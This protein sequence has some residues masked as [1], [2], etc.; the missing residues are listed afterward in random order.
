[1]LFPHRGESHYLP[2]NVSL[3]KDLRRSFVFREV[4]TAGIFV[5][6]SCIIRRTGAYVSQEGGSTR[7]CIWMCS[8]ISR[9]SQ[10]STLDGLQW[11]EFGRRAWRGWWGSR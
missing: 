9:L 11:L 7:E 6:I 2:G 5:N 3:E 4:A 8:L 1:V 10:S